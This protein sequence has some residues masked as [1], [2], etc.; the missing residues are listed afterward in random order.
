MLCNSPARGGGGLLG[1]LTIISWFA[2]RPTTHHAL[3]PVSQGNAAAQG[4]GSI[5]IAG[6][7]TGG[8]YAVGARYPRGATRNGGNYDNKRGGFEKQ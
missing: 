6:Q 8:A 3:W 7:L 2:E 5:E 1:T 4:G